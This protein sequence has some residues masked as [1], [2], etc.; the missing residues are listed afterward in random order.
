MMYYSYAYY[1]YYSRVREYEWYYYFITGARGGM[2]TVRTARDKTSTPTS[3]YFS[4]SFHC[5]MRN[6]T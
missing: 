3:Q 5:D 1:F 2:K 6:A 4:I